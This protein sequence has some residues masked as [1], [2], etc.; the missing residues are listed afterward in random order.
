MKIVHIMDWYMPNMS[1]QENFLPSEEK[2][3]GNEVY[4]ITSDKMPTYK[5]YSAHIGKING[6][7]LIG[8][9]AFEENGVQIFRLPS[10]FEVRSS[11]V[12]F[13][14]GLKSKLRELKPDI[15]FAHSPYSISTLIAILYSN[16]VGYKLF[17]DDHT[18]ETNF[19]LDN[20]IKSSYVSFV[21][22]FY[23]IYGNR[24]SC[25]FPITY[26]AKKILQQTLKIPDDKI[27]F[28]PLGANTNLFKKSTELRD[29]VRQ[30]LKVGANEKLLICSGKLDETKKIGILIEALSTVVQKNDGVKLLLIG[31]GAKDYMDKIKK[32][33]YD[34]N[35]QDRVISIDFV[36]YKELPQFYN[37]ADIG[38]WPG[39]PTIT[40][41]EAIATGLPVIITADDRAFKHIFENR[42]AIGFKKGD[43]GDLSKNITELIC[44]DELRNKIS[45]NCLKLSTE[46]LSW[47]KI[48][49]RSINAY[50][51]YI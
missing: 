2:K 12:I 48:A 34:K 4:I 7:R 47:S 32:L 36:P 23:R 30:R 9:G 31:N 49:Q 5:G 35:L 15:V 46:M 29:I 21:K 19:L 20:L 41:I 11:N 10:I 39:T 45:E 17:I 50:S 13:F 22:L 33:I 1:Y 3:L 42:A 14:T 6:N 24:V 40:I 38:V 25:Y 37:A 8:V 26:S 27:Q 43:A 51:N 44:D 28:L 16:E 18:H